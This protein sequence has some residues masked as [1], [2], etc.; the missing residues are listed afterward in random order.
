MWLIGL[1]RSAT[2]GDYFVSGG[3]E[4]RN[5]EGADVAGS[6]DDDD[7]NGGMG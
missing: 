7:S 1:A 5:E 2:G 6:A 3:D 4:P